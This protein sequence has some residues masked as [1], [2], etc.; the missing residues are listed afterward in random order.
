MKIYGSEEIQRFW[1]CICLNLWFWT[2]VY[3]NLWYSCS[4]LTLKYLTDDNYVYIGV[5]LLI[6]M[7]E[8]RSVLKIGR[9]SNWIIPFSQMYWFLKQYNLLHWR[10]DQ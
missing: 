5:L 7:L 3:S 4:K 2:N 10:L 1:T 8:R 6:V 9:M